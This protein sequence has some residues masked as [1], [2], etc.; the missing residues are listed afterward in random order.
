MTLLS[1]PQR[2]GRHAEGS[3]VRQERGEAEADRRESDEQ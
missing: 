1:M 3:G 2:H